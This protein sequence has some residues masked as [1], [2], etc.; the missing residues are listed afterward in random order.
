M[1]GTLFIIVWILIGWFNMTDVDLK[2]KMISNVPIIIDGISIYSVSIKQIAEFGYKKYNQAIKILCISKQEIES[3]INEK[4]S[5]LEFLQMNMI[6]DPT[7]KIVL[8]EILSLICKANV[9]YSDKQECFVIGGRLLDKNNFNEVIDII[10]KINSV[11]TT[12]EPTEHPS[13][14]KAKM[15]LQKR[16][17]ARMKLMSSSNNNEALNLY[18]LVSIVAVGLKLPIDTVTEYSIYQLLDQFKRLMAKENYETSISSLLHGANKNDL[19][20]KHWT[21]NKSAN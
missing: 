2:L 7:V 12:N 9:V 11:G 20:L 18:D 13:N 8:N 17:K 21:G 1:G 15:I 14:E 19:E 16:R 6:F 5:P 10:R 3:L 4:I